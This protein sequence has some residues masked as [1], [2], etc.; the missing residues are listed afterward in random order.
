MNQAKS[1]LEVLAEKVLNIGKGKIDYHYYQKLAR[2]IHRREFFMET[3]LMYENK[4]KANKDRLQ[5]LCN[6][7]D[8][9]TAKEIRDMIENEEITS[10]NMN[11]IN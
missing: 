11:K 10:N 6:L 5:N 1:K 4:I 8:N 2:E 3:K 9:E 7:V